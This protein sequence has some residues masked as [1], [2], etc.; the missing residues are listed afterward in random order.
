MLSRNHYL[1]DDKKLNTHKSLKFKQ[2]FFYNKK[3][4]KKIISNTL[5]HIKNYKQCSNAQFVSNHRV[6]SC[7]P[8]DF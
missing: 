6:K 1:N 2:R 5:L 7:S 3:D 8:C 4:F